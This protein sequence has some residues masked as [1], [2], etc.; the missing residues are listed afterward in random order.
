MASALVNYALQLPIV[1][2]LSD[3]YDQRGLAHDL[4]AQAQKSVTSNNVVIPV[5]QTFNVLLEAD[6]FENLPQDPEGLKMFVILFSTCDY[7]LLI[8]GTDCENSSP[9]FQEMHH[10]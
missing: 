3:H 5:L 6:V 1:T 2:D 8:N 7:T 9:L 4:L 10:A